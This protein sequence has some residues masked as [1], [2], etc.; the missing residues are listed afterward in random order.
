M[1]D[2]VRERSRMMT[3]WIS[4]KDRLPD[5]SPGKTERFHIYVPNWYGGDYAWYQNDVWSDGHKQIPHAY[6]THWQPL[7]DPPETEQEAR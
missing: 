2:P 1:A 6:V 5:V 3:D 4:V 7:P